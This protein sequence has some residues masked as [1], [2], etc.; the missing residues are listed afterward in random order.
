MKFGLAEASKKLKIEKDI[1][2]TMSIIFA[3]YLTP[4]A[5]PPS[6]GVREFSLDDLRVLSYVTNY[7]EDEPDIEYIKIGLNNRNHFEYPYNEFIVSLT[8][9][10]SNPP[11]NI[12]EPFPSYVLFNEVQDGLELFHLATAYKTGGD[13]LADAAIDNHNGYEIIYP[14]IYNYRHAV[15]LYL[16]SYV[17]SMGNTHSLIILHNKF[18]ELM[19]EKYR[20]HPA[21]WFESIIETLHEFD[22]GGTSFRYGTSDP[23]YE[24]FVDLSVLKAKMN[25]LERAFQEIKLYSSR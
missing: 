6:G 8:P 19:M 24:V 17:G 3:D 22:P 15:E 2:K 20:V 14:I 7:W 11:D 18:K 16:K 25:L 4:S 13:M 5:C 12:E 23:R 9:I 21:E 10:F 1:V